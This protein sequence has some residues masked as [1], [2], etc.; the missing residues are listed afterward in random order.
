MLK[1]LFKK[2][3]LEIN[4]WLIQDKKSGKQRSKSGIALLIAV[5]ILL[6]FFLGGVFFGVGKMLCKP[7]VSTGA[8][9]LYFAL[10]GLISIL[11]A[12]FG[13]V[14][15]TYAT[16]FTAK[17]NELLLSMPIPPSYILAVRLFGVWFWGMIY[18]ILV[19]IPAVIVYCMDVPL[20]TGGVIKAV[21]CNIILLLLLSVFVLSLS[22]ILGWVVAKIS[23]KMKNK[24][25]GTVIASLVFIGVYYFCYSKAYSVLQSILANAEIIEKKVRG[26]AFPLY[27]MGRAGEGN[28]L[29]LLVTALIITAI[30]AAVYFVMTRTFLKMAVSQ[31]AAA[32]RQ[33]KIS[34]K[35]RSPEGAFLFKELKRFTSSAVYMLNCGL[36][37]ILLPAAGIFIL[38][39]SGTVTG[40]IGK[41]PQYSDLIYL[42]LCGSVCIMTTMNDITAPSVSLEGKN[43]WLAQVLPV[44]PW[45]VLAAK[46]KLHFMLTVIP[47]VFCSVC[48]IITV[49]PGLLFSVMMLI[50]PVIFVLL[51]ACFGLFLNLKM[52]NLK[53]TDETVPV[54]QSFGVL[55]TLFAGWGFTILMGILYYAVHLLVSAELFLILCALFMTALSL[56]LVHW[57]KYNGSK[58]FAEL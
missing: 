2:Q 25:I 46:L 54:K 3:L 38:I 27:C 19:F 28:I 53:W 9:W 1:A 35:M 13:T 36:G 7:L 11:L 56:I 44:S 6:F 26:F 47:T 16:L 21:I 34:M 41:F 31:R 37:T 30:F 51:N 42:V 33:K 17:D 57:I 32:T 39:K 23:T 5:Y 40:F 45:K 18:E 43:L 8:G 29:S 52:P 22:C 20:G 58:I 55:I 10:M 24:S 15:N 12:V 14:F 48:L 50:L 4:L 49:Q